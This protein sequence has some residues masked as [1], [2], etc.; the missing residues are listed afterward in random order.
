M[1]HD[2]NVQPLLAKNNLQ[3]AVTILI[4]PENFNGMLLLTV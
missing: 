3:D 2:G 4:E 1:S